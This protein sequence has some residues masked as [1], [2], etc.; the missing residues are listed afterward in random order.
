MK[1]NT[2]LRN[3]GDVILVAREEIHKFDFHDEMLESIEFTCHETYDKTVT[4]FNVNI[5][6]INYTN[7]LISK[8]QENKSPL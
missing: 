6:F 1:F 5:G 8:W 2:C 4:L 7:N 3:C